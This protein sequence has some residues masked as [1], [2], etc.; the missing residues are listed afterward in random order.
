MKQEALVHSAGAISL[1]LLPEAFAVFSVFA[2]VVATFDRVYELM[3]TVPPPQ[4]AT[5]IPSLACQ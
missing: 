4:S 1:N 2:L 5:N 3:S